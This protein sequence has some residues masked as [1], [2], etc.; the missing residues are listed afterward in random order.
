MS[1]QPPSEAVAAYL[2]RLDRELASGL[3]HLLVLALVSKSG[4][5]HGYGLIRAMEEATGGRQFWKEGTIYPMLA[6]LDRDG[7]VASRWGNP[8]SGPRRKY[9]ELT[10]AGRQVL[11]L[12]VANWHDLRAAVDRVVEA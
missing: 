10:P 12:G 5:L 4:P 7:L 1:L 11:R 9:Y 8:T 2:D 6:S 3:Q